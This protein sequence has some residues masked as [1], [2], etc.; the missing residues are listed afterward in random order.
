MKL[1]SGGDVASS[2]DPEVIELLASA[3]V[4]TKQALVL[5]TLI[6]EAVEELT[7][8]VCSQPN[9]YDNRRFRT[10]SYEGVDRRG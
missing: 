6:N 5:S 8:F 2:R 3:R 4:L 9:S 10:E 1:L 7:S